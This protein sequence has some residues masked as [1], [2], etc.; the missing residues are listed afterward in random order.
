MKQGGWA[1][2]VDGVSKGMQS[3][4]AHFPG[5]VDAAVIV[6]SRSAPAFNMAN[7]MRDA[8]DASFVDP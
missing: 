5:G 1:Y 2:T 4:A 6:N 7:V 3:V 8:F